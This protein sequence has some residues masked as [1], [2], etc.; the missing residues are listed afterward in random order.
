M[1]RR[2]DGLRVAPQSRLIVPSAVDP[3]VFVLRYACGREL[4]VRNRGSEDGVLTDTLRGTAGPVIDAARVR[5]RAGGVWQVFR[6]DLDITLVQLEMLLHG[7]RVGAVEM[8]GT[9]CAR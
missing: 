2:V 5:A 8:T 1:L 3:S 6:T 9:Q 4:E 7:T